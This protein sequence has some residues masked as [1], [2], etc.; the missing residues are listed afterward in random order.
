MQ[1]VP[2]SATFPVVPSTPAATS[3]VHRPE[4][5]ASAPVASSI[6]T[7]LAPLPQG[8][9]VSAAVVQ[10]VT[11]ETA[12]VQSDSEIQALVVPSVVQSAVQSADPSVAQ[13]AAVEFGHKTLLPTFLES[14]Q[15]EPL[16][17]VELMQALELTAKA[18]L[19][20]KP[21]LSN[22]LETEHHK[23]CFKLFETQFYY[24]M[25]IYQLTDFIR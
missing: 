10:E 13:L 11:S 2:T 6:P 12:I 18:L 16:V 15:P 14:G 25:T 5:T 19:L 1:L 23:I 20:K 8:T 3:R 7:R 17:R 24:V 21:E 4:P 9:N 22:E